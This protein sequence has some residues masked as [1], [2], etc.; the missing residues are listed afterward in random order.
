MRAVLLGPIALISAYFSYLS[1]THRADGVLTPREDILIWRGSPVNLD[2]SSTQGATR[3][4]LINQGGKPVRILSVESGCGCAKPLVNVDVVAP[5][6]VATVDVVAAPL[7]FGQKDVP[8]TIHT[9]STTKPN[10]K[11]TLRIIGTRNP[12]FLYQIWGDLTFRGVYKPGEVREVTI[13]TVEPPGCPEVPQVIPDLPFLKLTEAGVEDQPYSRPGTLLRQRNY[14]VEFTG[15][16]PS[17]TFTGTIVAHDPWE[18]GATLSLNVSGQFQ[19]QLK[20]VPATINLSQSN[21]AGISLF[22]FAPEPIDSLEANVEGPAGLPLEVQM[23]RDGKPK[24]VHTLKVKLRDGA[25]P[26]AGRAALRIRRSGLPEE[27]IVPIFF[28]STHP[29]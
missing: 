13:V 1:I 3:F 27:S 24:R 18:A 6:M 21:R 14:R 2:R 23:Q 12:P 15:K 10:I 20:I 19:S 4:E 25:S 7:S 17:E 16:P 29:N 11:L 22:V 28:E 26:I 9:S 8:I 5:G